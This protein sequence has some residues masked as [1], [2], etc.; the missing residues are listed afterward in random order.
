MFPSTNRIAARHILTAVITNSLNHCGHSRISHAKAF[1]GPAGS[2]KLSASCSIK[3]G[4]ADDRILVRDIFPFG[5]RFND[6]FTASHAFADVIV[7]F[8]SQGDLNPGTEKRSEAL[9]GAT[10]QFQL[11]RSFR[12]PLLAPKV[13]NLPESLVPTARLVFLTR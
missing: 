10:A 6:N 5:G 4:I 12:Q 8:A 13:T 11:D 9:T 3:A 1:A 7:R 2:K